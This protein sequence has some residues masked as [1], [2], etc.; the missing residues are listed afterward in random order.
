M[1][2]F[3]MIFRNS[4]TKEVIFSSIYNYLLDQNESHGLKDQVLRRVVAAIP[5][6]KA[7]LVQNY[8]SFNRGIVEAEY[9]LGEIGQ[10]DSRIELST[11][12]GDKVA[13][14]YTEI[15]ILDGSARNETKL[16]R[17]IER[18]MGE[19]TKSEYE[20][21]L[22]LYLVPGPD[23][24]L[25]VAEVDTYLKTCTPDAASRIFLMFWRS[26]DTTK[27]S[28]TEMNLCKNSF[29][30][31]LQEL[32]SDEMKGL[33]PPV[34]TEVKY[35]LRS[36]INTIRNNFNREERY[37]PGRFPDRREFL[38]RIPDVHARLFE[39]LESK[40]G[41]K[42]SISRSNTSIGFPYAKA[43]EGRPNTLLRVLTMVNYRRLESEIF[44]TD[45]ADHLIIQISEKVWKL[46][47][48]M[49][50]RLAEMFSGVADVHFHQFHPN[51]KNNEPSTWISFREGLKDNVLPELQ[52]VIDS[53]WDLAVRRFSTWIEE[54]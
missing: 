20:N 21:S 22:L 7:Q 18:Y 48:A 26:G 11:T 44:E 24:T 31:I 2:V 38:S 16:G 14:L 12:A 41:A 29:E 40:T 47:D 35:V 34:S 32:L 30:D 49:K 43:P 27:L 9:P 17:Q 45:Y 4:G 3:D 19:I 1:N 53:F 28:I 51:G 6:E 15:K 23:S 33:I 50:N 5:D 54:L 46:D 25:A 39:Y 8:E 13:C 42:R 10:I 52:K 37:D 36:L